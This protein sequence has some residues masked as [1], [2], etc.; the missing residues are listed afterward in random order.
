MWDV[1]LLHDVYTERQNNSIP[2]TP[3]IKIIS[4]CVTCY[5]VYTGRSNNCIEI[6]QCIRLR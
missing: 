2:I 4:I 6:V 3:F 1:V 5:Y